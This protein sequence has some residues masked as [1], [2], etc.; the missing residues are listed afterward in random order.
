[1]ALIET[2]SNFVRLRKYTEY[3]QIGTPMLD[4]PIGIVPNANKTLLDSSPSGMQVDQALKQNISLESKGLGKYDIILIANNSGGEKDKLAESI[5]QAMTLLARG[6]VILI[7]NAF[8][9]NMNQV[10]HQGT[11]SITLW[12]L[13][14]SWADDYNPA[15]TSES[16]RAKP[17]M[18]SGMPYNKAVFIIDFGKVNMF[19]AGFVA[20]DKPEAA[21]TKTGEPDWSSLMIELV[22]DKEHAIGYQDNIN[23]DY[24]YADQ[25]TTLD[26]KEY[27]TWINQNLSTTTNVKSS[28][29]KEVPVLQPNTA[30]STGLAS[31][32]TGQDSGDATR[33]DKQSDTRKK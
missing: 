26:P 2:I 12:N 8:P 28:S 24:A 4:N 14:K 32:A 33:L 19:K 16:Q 17:V 22:V 11:G 29:T 1:M 25:H 18:Y 20:S 15:E 10:E 9:R 23:N 21:N 31:D 13:F 5:K 3:L 30:T 27:V 6:G 7:D